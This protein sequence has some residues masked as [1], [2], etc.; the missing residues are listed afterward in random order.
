MRIV[1][2]SSGAEPNL[3][4]H[5]SQSSGLRRVSLFSHPFLDWGVQYGYIINN[6]DL[7]GQKSQISV[8]SVPHCLLV[9]FFRASTQN[10][11]LTWPCFLIHT[12]GLVALNLGCSY[13]KHY[14]PK[15]TLPILSQFKSI[16]CR[17]LFFMGKCSVKVGKNLEIRGFFRRLESWHFSKVINLCF[18]VFSILN[19]T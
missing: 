7:S 10:D 16:V 2:F 11:R 9:W 3:S 6:R 12:S 15:K 5:T 19:G 18:Q 1:G 8:F 13:Q 14:G 4:I 17:N